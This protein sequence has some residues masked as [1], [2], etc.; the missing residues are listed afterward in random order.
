[1]FC[2]SERP[3]DVEQLKVGGKPSACSTIPTSNLKFQTSNIGV[4]ELLTWRGQI[5]EGFLYRS[6]FISSEEEQQLV[7]E[8]QE[9]EFAEVK[10]HGVTA[11]RRAVHFGRTYQFDTF[12]LGPAVDIPDFLLPL[13]ARAGE[14]TDRDPPEFAEALLTEYPPGAGIGWHRDAPHFGIIVGISL[15]AGCTMQFRPVES[16][17]KATPLA[18]RPKSLAQLLEPRSAYFI[19]GAARSEWQHH[20]PATKSLRYSI[21]FRTL[22][23]GS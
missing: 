18:K 19:S 1:L 20:I 5:P 6:E 10:M 11:K 15:L 16:G 13:R 3:P 12:K 22:R 2:R 9:L 23:K 8:I 4:S 14:L 17:R 7:R 21:T